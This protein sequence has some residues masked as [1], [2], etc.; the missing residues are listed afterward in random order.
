MKYI[1]FKILTRT[2]Q[3]I[4]KIRHGGFFNEEFNRYIREYEN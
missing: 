2:R 1:I 3:V 4:D